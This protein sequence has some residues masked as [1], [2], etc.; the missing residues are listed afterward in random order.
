MLKTDAVKK[1]RT[2]VNSGQKCKKRIKL[3]FI[4]VFHCKNVHNN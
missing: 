2:G 1:V 3:K 4:V